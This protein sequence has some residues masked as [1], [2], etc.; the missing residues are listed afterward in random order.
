MK[1]SFIIA[2]LNRFD[3]VIDVTNSIIKYNSPE[4]CEIIIVDQNSSDLLSDFFKKNFPLSNL[5]YVRSQVKGLSK[6]RN[7]GLGMSSG[8]IICFPDDDCLF[9]DDTIRMVCETLEKYDFCIGRIYN[10]KEGKNILKNWPKH[11]FE[12]TKFNS[13]F[14]N[15][16]ITLFIKKNNIQ[17][18]DERLG[19]GATYGSCEDADFVYRLIKK[20]NKGVYNSKIHLWHP[21]VDSKNIN[22]NKTF[23][24]ASGFGFFVKKDFD[25]TKF[26]LL[27][28]LIAK[29]ILQLFVS[30]FSNNFPRGYFKSFFKGLFCGLNAKM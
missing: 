27:V 25:F 1:V 21:E 29:K 20:N 8:D 6:N 2:T 30:F 16:S 14:I 19:V 17:N 9:Y 3:E 11:S 26:V 12:V 4:N 5:I 15:S 7:I 24:Y 18:F 10:R 22:L 28:L 13:Y 23:N